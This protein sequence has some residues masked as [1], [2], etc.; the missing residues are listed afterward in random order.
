LK[1]STIGLVTLDEFRKTK[2]EIEEARRREA[3]QMVGVGGER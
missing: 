3:A 1:K 2:S